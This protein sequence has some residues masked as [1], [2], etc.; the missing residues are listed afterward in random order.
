MTITIDRKRK[1]SIEVFPKIDD[2]INF[3]KSEYHLC[4]FGTVS[5]KKINKRLFKNV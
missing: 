4:F 5:L 3:L 1:E 2:F